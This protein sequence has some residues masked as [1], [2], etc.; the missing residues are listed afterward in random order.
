M[1]KK[2]NRSMRIIIVS[3]GLAVLIMKLIEKPDRAK[4]PAA[5][6][7]GDRFPENEFDDIW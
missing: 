6:R 7:D 3:A 5:G 2:L 4:D 1:F